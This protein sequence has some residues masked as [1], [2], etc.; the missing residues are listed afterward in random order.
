MIAALSSGGSMILP[1]G[2]T[3]DINFPANN[4]MYAEAIDMYD[5]HI[6]SSLL[7]PNL[8]G[9]TPTGQTGS[10]SQSDTQLK[11]FLWTLGADTAR[12]EEAINEQ[13]FRQLGEINYGDDLWPRFKFKPLTDNELV[14]LV[15]VWKDLVSGG[16]AQHTETDEAHTS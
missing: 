13:L 9:I 12:L 5:L 11:A 10:Y 4:V 15:K 16:A 14:E 7:V 1:K 3:L 2:V 6:S 8:M